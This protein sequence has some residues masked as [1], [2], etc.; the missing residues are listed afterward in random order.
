M[1]YVEKYNEGIA[2][3]RAGESMRQGEGAESNAAYHRGR[4]FAKHLLIAYSMWAI[5]CHEDARIHLAI[6]Q[7]HRLPRGTNR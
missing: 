6:A 2:A 3:Y 7:H 4:T 5:G 1:T